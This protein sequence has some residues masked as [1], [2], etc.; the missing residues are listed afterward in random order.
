MKEKK[1]VA[2]VALSIFLLLGC[3]SDVKTTFTPASQ[4]I[5]TVEERDVIISGEGYVPNKIKI[6]NKNAK[7]LKIHF[8]R[9]TNDTCARE[10][11]YEP[12]N[13]DI[14]LPLNQKVTVEF[15]V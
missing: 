7:I 8:L 14:E 11:I 12:Q 10:V 2:T 6:D 9:T 3:T 15:P 13:I 5:V 4:K 1:T